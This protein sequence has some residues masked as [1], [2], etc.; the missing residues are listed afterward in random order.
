MFESNLFH[1]I[2]VD[3]K[4]EFL[5]NYI[6]LHINLGDIVCISSSILTIKLQDYIKKVFGTLGFIYLK[7]ET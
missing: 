7:K 5:K 3:G 4:Y 6:K 2:M 1:S